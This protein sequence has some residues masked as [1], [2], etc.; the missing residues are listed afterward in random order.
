MKIA[1]YL[2]QNEE[3]LPLALAELLVAETS[4]WTNEACYGYCIE[5]MERAGFDRKDI[6]RVRRGLHEAFDELTVEEA[7]RKWVRW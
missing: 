7:E 3:A 4:I 2:K 6:E 5:A 1:E